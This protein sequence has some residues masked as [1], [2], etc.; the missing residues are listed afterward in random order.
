MKFCKNGKIMQDKMM[1]VVILI[2][3]PIYIDIRLHP[4]KMTPE[5][6]EVVEYLNGIVVN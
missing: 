2:P 5:D 4:F 1:T 3:P 6:K